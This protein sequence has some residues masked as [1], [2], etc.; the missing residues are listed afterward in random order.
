MG[1]GDTETIFFSSYVKNSNL[2]RGMLHTE[3]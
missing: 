1:A 2:Y 3:I